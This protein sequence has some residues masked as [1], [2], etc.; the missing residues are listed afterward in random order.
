LV[1][2]LLGWVRRE[3][4]RGVVLAGP[5]PALLVRPLDCAEGVAGGDDPFKLVVGEKDPRPNP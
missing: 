1:R 4:D 2:H 5:A 3:G